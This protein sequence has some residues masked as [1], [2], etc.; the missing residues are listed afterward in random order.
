M[1]PFSERKI[2]ESTEEM[3]KVF[4]TIQMN[5][6]ATIFLRASATLLFMTFRSQQKLTT[7]LHP[8]L[9]LGFCSSDVVMSSLVLSLLWVSSLLIILVGTHL[10]KCP[11]AEIKGPLCSLDILHLLYT[12]VSYLVE[13]KFT[14]LG[15][16][17]KTIE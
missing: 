14:H 3:T 2:I 12:F 1:K 7:P 5:S 10:E 6:S 17:L 13:I 16:H 4:S 15:V 11:H 8:R 9:L